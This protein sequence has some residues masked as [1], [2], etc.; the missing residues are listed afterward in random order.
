VGVVCANR[1]YDGMA[2]AVTPIAIGFQICFI[3]M[4]LLE[5]KCRYLDPALLVWRAA[6][7]LQAQRRTAHGAL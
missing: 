5:S 6:S 2:I 7:R 3:I 1:T 4:M